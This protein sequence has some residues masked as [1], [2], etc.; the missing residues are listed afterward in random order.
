MSI[1]NNPHH[2]RDF[3]DN[4]LKQ[5]GK[6]V[7]QA[8]LSPEQSIFVSAMKIWEAIDRNV[9]V[10][11][12]RAL[13]NP[14]DYQP[15]ATQ[16]LL[17]DAFKTRFNTWSKDELVFMIAAMHCEEMEKRVKQVVEQGRVGDNY[18]KPI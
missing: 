14:Y 6:Y 18:G 1:N 11:L 2:R 12:L 17:L 15:S 8:K 5:K 4:L 10:P 7:E 13:K 16:L 9:A 3:I